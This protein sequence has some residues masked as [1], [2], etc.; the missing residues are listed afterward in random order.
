MTSEVVVMNR[1]GVA[2]ASDSAATVRSNNKAKQFHADKLFM[3]SNT[4]PVGA[5]VYNN[6]LQLGVPWEVILKLFREHLGSQRFNHLR[7][8]SNALLTFLTDNTHLFPKT[9]QDE[10]YEDL[11][12]TLFA[13]IANEIHRR[14]LAVL[15][16]TDAVSSS[17]TRA[18]E[19]EVVRDALKDWEEKEDVGCFEVNMGERLATS[20]SG[21]L[22]ALVAAHFHDA[23]SDVV[24]DLYKLARLVVNKAD[25]LTEFRSGLVIAGYGEQEYFPVMQQF[26][27]GPIFMGKPKYRLID[28]QAVS[29]DTP[30]IIKPFAQSDM[31][32][33][34]LNG[35][36]PTLER[37]FHQ[38][39][40]KAMLYAPPN[41]IDGFP[42]VTKARKEAYKAEVLKVS[43]QA[44]D[45]LHKK[46]QAFRLKKHHDPVLQSIEHLPKKE[47]AHVAASLVNLSS[48]QK[49]MTTG[50]DETVGGPIDVAV[51]SKGDG[52]VWVDRKHYFK[53]E[54][55]EH[56][57]RNRAMKNSNGEHSNESK[58]HEQDQ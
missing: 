37:Y 13:G 46:L 31:V 47:L 48:F 52:F 51:I 25:I 56:F 38:E 28:E 3:L 12:S 9:V 10:S 7:E 33:T 55:N 42:G 40:A 15:L 30:S 18:I 24:L 34:F 20:E 57:F 43:Q 19:A 16:K 53:A 44:F 36:S 21:R 41:I 29:R 1:L 23:T 45:T 58:E 6:S 22:S 32:E 50:E 14:K 11:I 54:F 4:H 8:Y 26:E 5:M 35:V 39:L 17:E 27:I 49:R 2:L